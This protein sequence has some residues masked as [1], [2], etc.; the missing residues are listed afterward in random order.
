MTQLTLTPVTAGQNIIPTSK[1]H[2]RHLQRRVD[3]QIR[4]GA[5]GPDI[6]KKT[7]PMLE[8]VTQMDTVWNLAEGDPALK[9][10]WRFQ[11]FK[12]ATA[13]YKYGWTGN[14]GNFGLRSDAF[15]LRFNIVSAA[16]N[17][18]VLQVVFPYTNIAATEG[19]KEDVNA[20]YDNT[21]VQADYI[22]HRKAMTSLVRDAKAINP[23]MPFAA[24]D[25]AG[26]WQ[27]VM[28][29]LTCGTMNVADAVT[30]AVKT[31]PI[32][33]NN[34]RRNKGKFITDFSG[35]TKA[36][37]PELAEVFISLREPAC[38]VDI[39]PCADDPGYPEQNYD[40]A[41]DACP[42]SEQVITTRPIL[43]TGTGT[44]EVAANSITCNGMAIVHDALTGTATLA[45]LVTQ[46]NSLLA[47]MGTW[48]VSGSDI[49][50]TG[51]SCTSISIPWQDS[52]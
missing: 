10:D 33:V 44:Y 21:R 30:G 49:T 39:P 40:S 28:D 2:A 45:N 48:A 51:T 24:R 46:M 41:N 19:I 14:V 43:N 18:V 22:W 4:A 50:L 37:Y 25:F 7:Q 11:Q 1:L 52:P 26:K 32:A 34:E 23:E 16:A 13:Y 42:T 27:F 5:V 47:A 20:D 9:D 3:P 36:E 38:I 6:N 15:S 31:I 8:L 29:N 17:Q 35:A 12:D